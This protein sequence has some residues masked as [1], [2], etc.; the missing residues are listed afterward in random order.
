LKETD[1][2]VDRN[3][4]RKQY[5]GIL[6]DGKQRKKDLKDKLAEELRGKLG[7]IKSERQ[8]YRDD[9]GQAFNEIAELRDQK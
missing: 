7:P 6:D 3:D 2:N 1:P 4:V 5:R 9:K 8:Q